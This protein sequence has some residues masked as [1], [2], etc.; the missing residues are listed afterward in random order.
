MITPATAVD[1]DLAR[2][3]RDTWRVKPRRDTSSSGMSS[4]A[5]E[6]R[7]AL[8]FFAELREITTSA[9]NRRDI[10]EGDTPIWSLDEW[11]R[12]IAAARA[13]IHMPLMGNAIYKTVVNVERMLEDG[14]DARFIHR[15]LYYKA[16]HDESE[17]IRKAAD[18]RREDAQKKATTRSQ[19]VDAQVEIERIRIEA[20][21]RAKAEF[22]ARREDGQRPRRRQAESV[23]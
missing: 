23:L 19:A 5:V 12:F 16:K 2:E 22:D 3:S 14:K 17:Q 15:T 13:T 7:P 21:E 11:R 20:R 9:A 6:I 10:G 18:E 8:P 4:F 1:A